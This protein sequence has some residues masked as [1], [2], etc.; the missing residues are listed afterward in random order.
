MSAVR[1]DCKE[2]EELI[3]RF[4]ESSSARALLPDLELDG[5]V[6]SDDKG[7][8][9]HLSQVVYSDSDEAGADGSGGGEPPK[10][11]SPEPPAAEAVAGTAGERGE[12]EG[13]PA[14]ENW[15]A[16]A[17]KAVAAAA[18][19]TAAPAAE[20][21]KV[22]KSK[23]AQS[24]VLEGEGAAAKPAAQPAAQ[25]VGGAA[26]GG[27]AAGGAAAGGADAWADML[28]RVGEKRAAD[29]GGMPKPHPLFAQEPGPART[30][31]RA[32]TLI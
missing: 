28:R 26:A 31:A 8:Q 2:K 1:R 11:Q 6:C 12:P 32:G 17:G 20:E 30:R 27:A 25:P 23:V 14:T 15:S 19:G 22:A 18:A 21:S 16:R 9:W 29:R 4:L 7:L 5:M 13:A 3:Q 24:K 10:K